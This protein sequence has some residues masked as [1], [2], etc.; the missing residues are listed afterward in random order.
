MRQICGISI[1]DT[2][3]RSYPNKHVS[4]QL[5]V[6]GTG[7]T[8]W[9]VWRRYSEFDALHRTLL[10]QFPHAPPPL[11]LPPKSAVS[12][13]SILSFSLTGN[14]SAADP[15]KIRDR[16]VGLEKYL[17]AM[18]TASDE[19]WRS[20]QAWADFLGIP[21]DVKSGVYS[22]SSVS[23]YVPPA[24][25]SSNTPSSSG[26]TVPVIVMD[27]DQWIDEYRT[28]FGE[29]RSIREAIATK[30]GFAASGNASATQ[31]ALVQIR[32]AVRAVTEHVALLD[33]VLRDHVIQSAITSGKDDR[34]KS[35]INSKDT[36]SPWASEP[37]S[38]KGARRAKVPF[39]A[40]SQFELQRRE[41]MLVNLKEEK[42][43]VS[44]LMTSSAQSASHAL[45]GTNSG[46][47]GDSS[48]GELLSHNGSSRINRRA[49][50]ASAVPHET[51]E[52]L[53]LTNA[54]L[55]QLQQ[56]QMNEQDQVLESLSTVIG[57]QREIGA[58]MQNELDL[59]NQMLGDLAEDVDR[60]S[61]NMKHVTKKMDIVRGVSK[62]R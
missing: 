33:T 60:V 31:M 54:G 10:A 39:Q 13:S 40:L 62:K 5:T 19:R 44:L 2:A 30:E 7:D 20:S 47:I 58:M 12:F 52:T 23:S 24:S 11:P 6:K 37:T 57:R 51:E 50:G 22:S 34:G 49:F 17:E 26:T 41:D 25:S 3:I 27:A 56:R 43:K 29:C 36:P 53:A 59:Q 35:A 8:T 9:I 55:V 46:G 14:A 32:N 21:F 18:R 38:P 28:V 45:M 1:T 42:D 4:Y 48:K 15:A 61:G 16:R